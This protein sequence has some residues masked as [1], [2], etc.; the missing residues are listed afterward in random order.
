MRQAN[1]TYVNLRATLD[2][3]DPF[4]DASKPVARKLRPLPG[5]AAAVR[6]RGRAHRARPAPRSCAR[7]GARQRPV[8]APADLPGAG[9][10]RAG[11]EAPQRSTSAPAQGRRRDPRRVPRADARRCGTVAP[12]VAHGRPYTTDFVGWMDDF[13]HTGA[14]D[15]LGSF[16]RAQIYFNAFTVQDG[17][18]HRRLIPLADRS[19]TSFKQHRP[20]APGQALPGRVPRRP[21]PTAPTC[22]SAAEQAGAGLPRGATAPRGRSPDAPAR[23]RALAGRCVRGGRRARARGRRA[24]TAARSRPTRSS[25]TTRSGWSEGGDLKIGGVKAGK[26]TGFELTAD[27]ALPH[28]RDARRSP[29]RAST[30][31][32]RDARCEVRAAV[33]DRRVLRGL[34]RSGESA[35]RSCPT[36]AAC[37]VEQTASTIPPDLINTV[38]RRP[39]RERFRLILSELG[40]GL[41]GPARGPERG[42]PPRPPGAAR[43]DRDDRDPA[44]PEQDHP[45]LHPRRR[46]GV[47][48]RWSP[49]KEDGGASGRARP[50]T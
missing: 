3:L 41:A 33:A 14:Y 12:I 48:R 25:S 6:A 28:D 8:R 13:S 29:S 49:V 44:R 20:P 10:H 5:R 31:C 11:G 7:R 39:Y 15:A 35:R 34:R 18:A 9:G 4:V 42:H 37:P 22:F 50:R 30:P 23:C 21:P 16:S 17:P 40:T 2:D 27:G 1:T 26:T 43:A 47:A 36:A 32:A 45:R 19:A 38:M 46:H 24:T